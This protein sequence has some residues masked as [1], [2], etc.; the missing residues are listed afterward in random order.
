[1][2]WGNFSDAPDWCILAVF[3]D[4]FATVTCQKGEPTV[5]GYRMDIR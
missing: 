1:M 5:C 2:N 3:E 4:G